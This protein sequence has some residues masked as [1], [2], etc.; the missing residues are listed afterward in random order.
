VWGLERGEGS[1]GCVEWASNVVTV[2]VDWVKLQQVRIRV[3]YENVIKCIIKT[4]L[5]RD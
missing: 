4:L 5:S 3:K 2:L 1:E